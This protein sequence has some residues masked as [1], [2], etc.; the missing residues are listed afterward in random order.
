M[1][2]KRG[3]MIH[4][5]LL[6]GYDIVTINSGSVFHNDRIAADTVDFNGLQ[7]IPQYEEDAYIVKRDWRKLS[8]VEKKTLQP[9]NNCND[10]N[11]V[12]LGDI[13]D[14]LKICFK[15]LALDDSKSRD[16]VLRKL[17]YDAQKTKKL[18][19]KLD[20]FLFNYANKKPYSFHCIGVNPP[21]IELVACDTT[22]LPPNFK[23]SDIRYMGL[24][25]DGTTLM[26]IY[27]AHKFG[28][29]ISINLSSESRHFI[30][31]NLS[32]IQAYNMLKKKMSINENDIN[33]ANIP[34]IFFKHFPDYPVLKIKLKPYQYYIAPTDNCFH[35][36]STLGNKN[37][38]ICIIYFGSFQY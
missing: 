7:Y 5:Q 35:D 37:L 19:T 8:A 24:H 25:N 2:L 9:N 3:I 26:S 22:K 23:P 32:M 4:N 34:Q 29:R 12:Y 11:T 6:E 18:S 36:G 20:S 28:N 15:Q 13:P 14:D 31:V 16:E 17:S 38:D 27:T 30:F 21:N 10:Y 1:K 33:I